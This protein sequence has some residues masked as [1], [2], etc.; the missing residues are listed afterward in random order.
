MGR[1]TRE[2]D[3]KTHLKCKCIPD[4]HCMRTGRIS[5]L[6]NIFW[7]KYSTRSLSHDH[8]LQ[9]RG[10]IV[11]YWPI[12][13]LTHS[14]QTATHTH[15]HTHWSVNTRT[16]CASWWQLWTK[17]TAERNALNHYTGLGLTRYTC[18]TLGKNDWYDRCTTESWL[19]YWNGEILD[20]SYM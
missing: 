12:I 15:T 7:I 4:W 18:I 1:I 2:Q 16:N 3:C 8:S 5:M 6:R 13:F 17:I 10:R 9:L 20:Y 11:K 14:A 19:L